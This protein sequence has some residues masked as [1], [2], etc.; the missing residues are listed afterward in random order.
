MKLKKLLGCGFILGLGIASSIP[1]F[2]SCQISEKYKT[3]VIYT[4]KDSTTS[5]TSSSTFSESEYEELFFQILKDYLNVDRS[6]IPADAT[7]DITVK[8]RKTINEQ[9]EKML[10][11]HKKAYEENKISKE[12]YNQ[13]LEDIEQH[14]NDTYDEI[15]CTISLPDNEE[16]YSSDNNYS[17]TFNADTKEVLFAN[18]PDSPEGLNILAYEKTPTISVSDYKSK[19]AA[20]IETYKIGGIE[21]PVCVSANALVLIYQDKNDATKKVTFSFDGAN[22][23]ISYIYVW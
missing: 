20:L 4:I 3:N 21:T 17:V 22:G 16:I 1:L 10:A 13:T 12:I 7:L 8:D 15:R 19:C 2:A 5:A 6:E 18:R 14:K 9:N 11:Y 23:N